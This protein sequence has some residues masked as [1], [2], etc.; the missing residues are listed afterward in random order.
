MNL[1]SICAVTVML[2]GETKIC[3][4]SLPEPGDGAVVETM[5]LDNAVAWRVK[6][7]GAGEKTVENEEWVF[8]FGADLRCWPISHAQGEYI[9]QKISTIGDMAPMPAFAP[10]AAGIGEMHNYEREMPGTAESPLVVEGDGWVAAL[11]DGEWHDYYYHNFGDELVFDGE[12]EATEEIAF[13][14][15]GLHALSYITDKYAR[16]GEGDLRA[17]FRW[18]RPEG[19]RNTK[20]YMNWA[21]GRTFIKALA[22]ATEGLSRVKSP[23]YN[24]T[25]SSR[26]PVIVARQRGE[27]WERPFMA[28]IDPSGCIKDVEFTATGMRVSTIDGRTPPPAIRAPRAQPPLRGPSTCGGSATGPGR[29]LPSPPNT[30]Q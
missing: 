6:Y 10:V 8:D 15:S 27:A 21:P 11:G 1:F 30:S 19:E 23:N 9:P 24:I 26:T 12:C 14:E 25:K 13:V 29:C 5:E 7:P 16:K 17:E 28:A 20:F 18:Q 22:P 4:V 3:E 2:G